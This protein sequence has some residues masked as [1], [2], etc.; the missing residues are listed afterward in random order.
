MTRL[1]AD[2]RLITSRLKE[3]RTQ[4]LLF[5]VKIFRALTT[6]QFTDRLRL[7]NIMEYDTFAKTL[8]ANLLFTYRVNAGTVFY[9]GVDDHYAQGDL[10]DAV[11]FPTREF[12]RTNRA[13][14]MKFSYLFRL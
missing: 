12:Q 11:R 9:V 1:N 3:P 5:D 7:R 2:V 4:A 14:F 10:I 8:G 6:F 13:F